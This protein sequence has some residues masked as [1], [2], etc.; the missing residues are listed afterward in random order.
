M[1][2]VPRSSGACRER[3]ASSGGAARGDPPPPP[4]QSREELSRPS[5]P[6]RGAAPCSDPPPAPRHSPGRAAPPASRP[7]ATAGTRPA[8]ASPLPPPRYRLGSATTAL[9]PPACRPDA[10]PPA[11]PCRLRRRRAMGARPAPPP[12]FT[13]TAPP[14]PRPGPAAGREQVP[15]PGGRGDGRCSRTRQGPLLQRPR[16]ASGHH[17]IGL[18][19]RFI[20]R[21]VPV[22]PR[23]AGT[24]GAVL[25]FSACCF[26]CPMPI[27][28]FCAHLAPAPIQ[29]PLSHPSS[30]FLYW[31]PVPTQTSRD[32]PPTPFPLKLPYACSISSCRWTPAKGFPAPSASGTA[33]WFWSRAQK[34]RGHSRFR[35][36]PCCQPKGALL[37]FSVLFLSP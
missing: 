9:P 8:A 34:G 25:G 1:L 27:Y 31:C 10:G 30:S 22:N 24:T 15:G 20:R 37:A 11:P 18:S 17:S 35:V 13:A 33:S 19:R 6:P 14:L 2:A 32:C 23:P 21:P 4:A 12:Y 3:K 26:H 28:P 29:Q 7:P 16:T 36:K 5:R